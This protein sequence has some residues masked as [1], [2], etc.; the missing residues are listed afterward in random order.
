MATPALSS[1]SEERLAASTDSMIASKCKSELSLES[2]KIPAF[3]IDAM[4]V[5]SSSSALEVR[6]SSLIDAMTLSTNVLTFSSGSE[7]ET[8]ENQQRQLMLRLCQ[9]SLSFSL[10]CQ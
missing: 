8:E 7:E 4:V 2:E 1:E 5:P 10:H 9:R 3:P 6:S